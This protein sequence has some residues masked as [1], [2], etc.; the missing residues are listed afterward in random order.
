MQIKTGEQIEHNRMKFWAKCVVSALILVSCLQCAG[1][2][3]GKCYY[4]TSSTVFSL[5]FPP[6]I[7]ELDQNLA[8]ES[9]GISLFAAYSLISVE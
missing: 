3:L 7:S 9:L 1:L 5:P 2:E 8:L 4:S 6:I